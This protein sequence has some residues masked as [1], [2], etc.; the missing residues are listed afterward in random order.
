MPS[1]TPLAIIPFIIQM[2]YIIDC[3]VPVEA[4]LFEMNK[5]KAYLESHVKVNGVT[6]NLGD[7][8]IF[9]IDEE[10]FLYID[11]SESATLAKRA[12]KFYIK[13]YLQFAEIRDIFRCLATEEGFALSFYKHINE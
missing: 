8:I 5:F 4:S 2:Q 12:I 1:Q 10:R 6:N 13:R 11:I 3:S 7:D 9:S